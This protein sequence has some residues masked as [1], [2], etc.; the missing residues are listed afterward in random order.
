[1][2]GKQVDLY[3]THFGIRKIF[4]TANGFFLH[5]K[6]VRFNGV[7]LNYD[8]GTLGGAVYKRADECKLQIMKDMHG[9]VKRIKK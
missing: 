3:K 9:Q 5:D 8:N 7:C 4:Y 1:M 2:D 6:Q